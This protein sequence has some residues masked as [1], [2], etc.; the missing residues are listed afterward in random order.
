MLDPADAIHEKKVHNTIDSCLYRNISNGHQILT[1]LIIFYHTLDNGLY[2][3]CPLLSNNYLK[4]KKTRSS[5][6]LHLNKIMIYK[7]T[8]N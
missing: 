3:Y 5:D 6:F 8:R 7:K 4:E 2:K 1:S